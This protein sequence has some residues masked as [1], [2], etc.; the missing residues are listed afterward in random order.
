MTE[1]ELSSALRD[2]A[3]SRDA[4][5]VWQ[6]DGGSS[7]QQHI[8]S[9][10][11]RFVP[12]IHRTC[13]GFEAATR[14]RP[15]VPE[16]STPGTPSTSSSTSSS[17]SSNATPGG[18]P[19]TPNAVTATPGGDSET[20][21]G[22][23]DADEG[24][25]GQGELLVRR[26]LLDPLGWFLCGEDPEAGFPRLQLSNRPA[27][28]CGHVFRSG[29]PTY[30]CRE[31][32]ADPTCVLCMDCFQQ[33]VH[34]THRYRMSTS[35]G[36]GVCD[37]G[38]REA[39]RTGP[40]CSM[41]SPGHADAAATVG[42]GVLPDG[43]E[44]R[45]R[46]LFPVLLQ[47]AIDALTWDP[48]SGPLLRDFHPQ[49]HTDEVYHCVLYNDEV[50]TFNDVIGCLVVA[51]GCSEREAFSLASA[52]DRQG[53]KSVYCGSQQVCEE[54]K[55]IIVGRSSP[56]RGQKALRTEVESA[57][58]FAHQTFATRL[59]AWLNHI[60]ET[61]EGLRVL[62]CEALL[63]GGD[64]SPV[65][66]L[67]LQ[68]S[69]LWKGARSVHYDLIMGSLLLE[70]EYKRHFAI[71]FTRNYR[72]LQQDF[73]DDDHERNLSVTSLSVQ[74]FTVPT[75]ARYLV[76]E[77]D[78]LSILVKTMREQ[79]QEL[80][81]GN[82][83]L[84][85]DRTDSVQLRRALHTF[86]DLKFIL[87]ARPS[88]WSDALRI[89][90]LAGFQEFM[91][92][93]QVLQGIEAVTRQLS[94]HVEMDPEWDVA[95]SLELAVTHAIT[96]MQGWCA[97]NA[98]VL[99]ESYAL[100]VRVLQS[101]GAVPRNAAATPVRLALCGHSLLSMPYLV[102]RQPVSTHLPMTRF[103]AG[104]Y[105][106]V[107]HTGVMSSYPE[108]NL[109]ESVEPQDLAELPLR[110]LVLLAQVNAGMWRR[111]GFS[112]ANQ[113]YHY[114]SAM[115]RQ[116]MFDKDVL[117]LQIAASRMDPDEFLLLLLC[118]FELINV[119]KTATRH[120]GHRADTTSKDQLQ[121][122]SFLLEELLQLIIWI[123]AE[124]FV[125]GVSAVT[126]EQ[127]TRHE[128]VH[129]LAIKPMTHSELSKALP[130]NENDETG[131]EAIID[132]VAVFRK[133]GLTGR[134]VYEL[135][136][137]C[138][139]EY[140]P[141]FYHYRRSEQSKAEEAQKKLKKLKGEDSALPP[142]VPPPLCPM[143]EGLL[144]L[145]HCDT[146]VC[147][148]ACVLHW[149]AKPSGQPCSEAAL[150][151]A[152]HLMGLALM[153]EQKQ[154][155]QAGEGHE[156]DVS[157]CFLHKATRS[158]SPPD[159]AHSLLAQ[160]QALQAASHL[161][162]EKDMI[163]WT[164]K[165][166]ATVRMLRERTSQTPGSS[167]DEQTQKD[168]RRDSGERDKQERKRKAE[169]ARKRREKIMA[170][171]SA[172]QRSFMEENRA[173]FEQA[174]GAAAAQGS[175]ETD[176]SSEFG[177]GSS[178]CDGATAEPGGVC[179]GPRR[180]SRPAERRV[181]SCI[182]CQE[183]QEVRADGAA[184]VLAA[185]VQHSTVLAR[186]HA[187][188]DPAAPPLT[189]AAADAEPDKF[190]P[191]LVTAG[192]PVGVHSGSCGHVM[193]A[194]CWQRYYEPTQ[195]RERRQFRQRM[196]MDTETGEFLCPLCEGIS[197][198]V[199]PVLPAPCSSQQLAHSGEEVEAL[200]EQ[201]KL[202]RW[203]EVVCLRIAGLRQLLN[204]KPDNLEDKGDVQAPQPPASLPEG[205]RSILNY[206]VRPMPQYSESLCGMVQTFSMALYRASVSAHPNDQ[207]PRVPTLAWHTCAFTIMALESNLRADMKPLFGS[208]PSRQVE[209]LR[210][211]VRLAEAQY[212]MVSSA[213]VVQG[214]VL[215]LFS[216]LIPD[217]QG[218]DS[219]CLL[220]VDLTHLLLCATLAFPAL[221]HEEGAPLRPSPVAASVNELH[222]VTL[223]TMAHVLQ[224]LLTAATVAPTPTTEDAM[225]V[226]EE[227]G[228]GEEEVQAVEELCVRLQQ[229]TAG[230]YASRVPASR[231]ARSVRAGVAPF[232]RCA[233]TFF[234]LL[235]DSPPPPQ[236]RASG[237][238]FETL[239]R[240]LA[241]PTNLASLFQIHGACI[242]SLLRSWCSAPGVTR[243][244]KGARSAVTFPREENRLVSLPDDYSQLINRASLYTCPNGGAEGD[245][246]RSMALCLLCGASLCSLSL[247]CQTTLGSRTVGA[248]TLHALRCGGGVGIFL[249]VRECQVLLLANR[250][251]GCFMEAPYLDD[252]GETDQGLHRGNPLHL[253]PERLA[254]LQRL[255]LEHGVLHSIGH[256]Q[257]SQHLAYSWELF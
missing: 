155:Q 164:L 28:L 95:Y 70:A 237:L 196:P 108:M 165:L 63:S 57:S 61:C 43:V 84:H 238:E 201:L 30:S 169:A 19:E 109:L 191:L 79:L 72:R 97:S 141:F 67:M 218:E 73:L 11:A 144:R 54:I 134:G 126:A 120:S 211:L 127:V 112:L 187:T 247:C 124:R 3:F 78:A 231:L 122:N 202:S 195:V 87:I 22:G 194:H 160:L 128:V 18:T 185:L 89:K 55:R 62:V 42:V 224:V 193:H 151:R 203:L 15:S 225:E 222:L 252:Y 27:Q 230:A 104:L 253:C 200:V 204:R 152:L 51:I 183:E 190:D 119:F 105:A 182:L 33:S 207:D 167:M 9:H 235:H 170:Q 81:G 92:F 114:H 117:M 216:V 178:G 232:L 254:G 214:H 168:V 53:R 93:L 212:S 154:L 74:V 171:M 50:H 192:L 46:T 215:R 6:R 107:S 101:S 45:A 96:M 34:R 161:E 257:E 113:M 150:Q 83:A 242:D 65:C 23:N 49:T 226:D 209:C 250:T 246:A 29:E 102:S 199:V 35:G 149:A 16:G 36:G 177:G 44:E 82:G 166:F 135:R 13:G 145:L 158:G 14:T 4:A 103:L 88:E 239:C 180:A 147:M 52:V 25:G 256:S 40:H 249:R 116:E 58:L 75:L 71:V 156:A 255:W 106:M 17:S 233:A 94:Q 241:L 99:V 229:L 236:L 186:P 140:N 198:A 2:E 244:L 8:L 60:C 26:V 31:C 47:Y 123:L 228:Y 146:F 64:A 69:R 85:P 217:P 59:L 131:M 98:A 77:E 221:Y 111:N 220:D 219:P 121:Q 172:M 7:L 181:L 153:E 159:S 37:C 12:G 90:F 110:C 1:A 173:L 32:A 176:G 157:F 188:S 56:R 48:S 38:D 251:R 197:N 24:L 162:N 68:D 163:A 80:M 223:V 206:G 20:A 184:M 41:H 138:T 130:E 132:D 227:V 208:L 234:C 5:W 243:L 91:T 210:S 175:T 115:C 142:P 118:R 21:D 133:P 10:L 240:Y 174:G 76:M 125:P 148:L 143:F 248:C 179:V 100:C 139:A 137:E 205:F 245:A 136:P 66:M 129:Q 39:W 86:G 213:E 189:A